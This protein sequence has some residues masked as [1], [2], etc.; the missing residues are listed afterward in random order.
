MLFLSEIDLN[1]YVS[2]ERVLR[3]CDTS[4]LFDKKKNKRESINLF[5]KERCTSA[6]PYTKTFFTNYKEMKFCIIRPRHSK[7]TRS[8]NQS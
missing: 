2:S 1:F 4:S 7:V 5:I 6:L 3:L 8:K